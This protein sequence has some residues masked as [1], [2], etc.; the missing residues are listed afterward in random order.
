M[1]RAWE[2]PG[3]DNVVRSSSRPSCRPVTES[4]S[5][6]TPWRKKF[7][8][9]LIHERHASESSGNCTLARCSGLSALRNA[10]AASAIGSVLTPVGL[11]ANRSDRITPSRV[12][13]LKGSWSSVRR[14]STTG[15]SGTGIVSTRERADIGGLDRMPNSLQCITPPNP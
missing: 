1:P 6:I 9:T 3:A 10:A 12:T 11:S 15:C 14:C 7:M 13:P 8:C 5:S 2:Y 4:S